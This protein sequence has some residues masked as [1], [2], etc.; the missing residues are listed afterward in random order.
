[1]PQRDI[2]VPG[3]DHPIPG[4]IKRSTYIFLV[5]DAISCQ[6][7]EPIIQCSMSGLVAPHKGSQHVSDDGKCGSVDGFQRLPPSA[8][9]HLCPVQPSIPPSPV[10]TRLSVY[11]VSAVDWGE[12]ISPRV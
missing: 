8:V 6:V 5:A 9:L 4:L 7:A 11:E 1:M 3:V 10:S 2:P 12:P